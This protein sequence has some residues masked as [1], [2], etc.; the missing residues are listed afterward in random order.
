MKY[1]I[2]SD[3]HGSAHCTRLL[4]ER[5]RQEN[6]DVLVLLG[7][8]LYH[9]PRNNLPD[10]YDPK[11]VAAL[12]NGAGDK[13]IAVRGN[14]EA[15]VD[16]MM[17]DFPCMA[18]YVQLFIE[19]VPFFVTHGHIYNNDHLPPIANAQTILLHGHTHIPADEQYLSHRY[20]NPGSTTI[21][22]KD[23]PRSYMVIDGNDILWKKLDTQEIYMRDTIR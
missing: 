14:C 3:L 9:G 21:P 11:T 6:A 2:A 20:M 17:L 23:S 19:G 5:F 4:L 22:K 16:Q 13:I 8:L 10:E 18:D 7:D 15:E 12:L 1:L